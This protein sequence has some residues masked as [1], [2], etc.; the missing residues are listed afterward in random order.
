MKDPKALR[1]LI[2]A[3]VPLSELLEKAGHPLRQTIVAEQMRCPFHGKDISASARYYPETNSMHC[4]TCKKSWDPISFWMQY[5]DTKFISACQSLADIYRLDLTKLANVAFHENLRINKS[6]YKINKIDYAMVSI[7]ER[8]KVALQVEDPLTTAK[9]ML[10]LAVA[11]KEKDELKF[12]KVAM[13]L[14]KK[15]NKILV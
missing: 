14:V 9:M 5:T 10:L 13:P 12:T 15:L 7:I 1:E 6:H 4:F 8:M 3:N 2:T 11:R